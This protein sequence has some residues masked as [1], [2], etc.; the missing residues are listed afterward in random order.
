MSDKKGTPITAKGSNPP[1]DK[2]RTKTQQA[3]ASIDEKKDDGF[4]VVGIGASAGGLEAFQQF[5]QNMPKDPGMGF[6]LVPH[7]D[8]QHVSLMP[9]LIQRATPM[10]VSQVVD[11]MEVRPDSVYIVPPNRE[12]VIVGGILQT[13]EPTRDR[14]GRMPIDYFFRSLAKDQGEKAI[15]IVLSGMGTDG[16]LGLRAVKGELGAA[17]VQT[18][19]SAKYDSMPRS[20]VETGLA[21]Y[22][23]PPAKMPEQLIVYTR[24]AVV[25]TVHEGIAVD[26][27]SANALQKVFFLL[28]SRTGH[29]FSFYKQTTILRRVDRRMHLHRLKDVSAY[30]HYLQENTSE[31]DSL[32]KE[33][34]IGVTSF[35]R[36]AEAFEVL[37]QKGL[38]QILEG[39]PADYAI[40]AWVPGCSTGEEAYSIGILLREWTEQLGHHF[41]VQIFATDI[42]E[43]AIETARAGMYPA[44]IASDVSR[45]RLDRFFGVEGSFY[46]VRKDLRE[47]LVFAPQDVIKD[48]PF[49]KLDLICCRNLLIYFTSV[50]QKKLLPVFHYSLRAGG[51]LF[52]G[53][54]ETIGDSTDL[55]STVDRKW[56]IYKRREAAPS[57]TVLG[58]FPTALPA[59]RTYEVAGP[60]PAA[61]TVAQLAEKALLD[62]YAPPSVTIDIGGEILYIHG[63]TGNYL[64]PPPGVAKWNINE[65]A[66]EGLK[67]ELPA[68][69]HKARSRQTEV[70]CKGLQVKT[71]GAVHTVNVTVRPVNSPEAAPGFLMVIFEDLTPPD[72]QKRGKKKKVPTKGTDKSKASIE[73]ELQHTKENL[74][75]TIEGL[76]TA[77]EE[78]KSANEELQSTNEE[79]QSTNE[80]LETSKEEQQSLHEELTTV[81]SELQGKVEAL[82]TAGND[83]KNLLD[84]ME[85]PTIFLDNDLRVK[86][87]TRH[88]TKMI[89]LIL[90]DVGRPI[91][92]IATNLTSGNLHEDASAVLK[93][94]VFREVEVQTKVGRWYLKRTLPYR[95]TE[96]VIDG[97]VITFVDIHEQKMALQR[98]ESLEKAM[99][100]T[101]AYADGIVN[102]VREP[103]LVLDKGL[104][105]VSANRSYYRFFGVAPEETE[106]RSIFE[107]GNG[108]W[109]VSELRALL[110]DIIP[111]KKF[112]DDFEVKREFP[113]IGYKRILLNARRFVLQRGDAELILLAM[114]DFTD[115]EGGKHV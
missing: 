107:L 2:V 83:M 52:L 96:N 49:T 89:N 1:S 108:Q 51:I 20:A 63:R 48:P 24:T 23:L 9:E 110:N 71:N 33:L 90:A 85:I 94:L 100:E 68:A 28:R 66:R 62:K 3:A 69:I 106:T 31:V 47:M 6:V 34:L 40:R 17:M 97:V 76:Q 84:G 78:L 29:D 79:L 56:K 102:T 105:V 91:N 70:V 19:E 46:R 44:T 7:L 103:L 12:L 8:P 39:K 101:L 60:K 45:D 77:N 35:F 88:A 36:D 113:R 67:I 32:F 22:V 30:V 73:E 72:V 75:V 57:A 11:G 104:S 114:E 21:D 43:G 86:R 38:P 98:A 54:S 37:K 65:M 53:S 18:P 82:T 58:P 55:F 95:T 81:N 111:K 92:H 4:Y 14:V 59:L 5:F 80:E 61:F 50:L 26:K 87:F 42:D 16:S 99:N 93:D 115:R 41:S 112:L 109:D 64:E 10:T 25:K 74:Q 27:N 13:L 15:C